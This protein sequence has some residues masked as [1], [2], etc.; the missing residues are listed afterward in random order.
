MG[1]PGLGP[2]GLLEGSRHSAHAAR[3]AQAAPLL[4]RQLLSLSDH[5]SLSTDSIV[6]GNG[7]Q[8]CTP[9]RS[10]NGTGRKG[11]TTSASAI[12][13]Y[14][15]HVF[16]KQNAAKTLLAHHSAFPPRSAPPCDRQRATT[17][18]RRSHARLSTSAGGTGAADTAPFSPQ[19]HLPF[20]NKCK[21]SHAWDPGR[22][23]APAS[24]LDLHWRQ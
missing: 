3:H 8:I 13:T 14:H 17:L 15:R 16:Y 5:S 4:G 7:P 24:P 20:E 21:P 19:P 11:G 10:A 12:V 9:P 23:R 1:A 22:R 2:P 6:A 18:P